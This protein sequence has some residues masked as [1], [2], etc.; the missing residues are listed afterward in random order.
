MTRTFYFNT[1]VKSHNSAY[2]EPGDI[3]DAH[4]QRLIPFICEDVPD[5]ATF[6][7]GADEPNLH[8]DA[9]YIV[10]PI[11]GGNLLSKYAYFQTPIK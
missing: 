6:A 4:D 5:G 3:R 7:F 2:M 1:G 11:V 10:R 9:G 8:P